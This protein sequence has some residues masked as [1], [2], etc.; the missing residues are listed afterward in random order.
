MKCC[1]LP[2]LASVLLLAATLESRASVTSLV[3]SSSFVL[4]S[5]GLLKLA[6]RLPFELEAD[7]ALPPEL[8]VLLELSCS[9]I[10]GTITTVPLSVILP[11]VLWLA[12]LAVAV[13]AALP[14]DASASLYA[15]AAPCK[16]ILRG[17]N[18]GGAVFAAVLLRAVAGC[19]LC[20]GGLCIYT[21]WSH[22]GCF[23]SKGGYISLF[24]PCTSCETVKNL[25]LQALGGRLLHQGKVWK[26]LC[27]VYDVSQ[28]FSSDR[29]HPS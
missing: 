25:C 2:D 16:G 28:H 13:L 3:A 11:F 5:A 17:A 22:N 8:A 21:R 29:M 14:A 18:V 19:A 6:V 10:G 20:C 24:T 27:V 26:Q 9:P 1:F 12:A 15:E 23:T 4:A 7:P